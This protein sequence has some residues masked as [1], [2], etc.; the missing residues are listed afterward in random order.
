MIKVH[1]TYKSQ[2][3]GWSA[4]ELKFND[5]WHMINWRNKWLG[6]Y[7]FDQFEIVERTNLTTRE[8][9]I[10]KTFKP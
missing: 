5:V 4:K 9:E 10:L 1:M 6:K 2:Y 7:Q 8:E 3:G